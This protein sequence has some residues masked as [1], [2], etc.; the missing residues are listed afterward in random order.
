M[1]SESHYPS[2][3]PEQ[4]YAAPA[5]RDNTQVAHPYGY[6]DE[7][8]DEDDDEIDLRELWQVI[9]R[10]KW[11]ILSIALLVFILSLVITFLMTPIYRAS[12]TLQIDPENQNVLKYDIQVQSQATSTNA[13]DFY[14]TQYELLKSNTLANRVI[15]QL[16]LESALKGDQ[17]A[18]PFFAEQLDKFT[19]SFA[20][21][22]EPANA[23]TTEE[24]E[25]IVGERPLLRDFT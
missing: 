10:R 2:N 8:S 13:K 22:P 17:L 24:A 20:T 15:E 23:S 5:L 9:V 11:L 21:S 6:K 7:R 1:H 3:L 19:A 25:L 14:Q 12:T 16:A 18:K 4:P